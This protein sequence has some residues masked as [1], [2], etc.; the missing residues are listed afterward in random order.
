MKNRNETDALNELILVEEMKYAHNL[1]QLK[2]QFHIAYES[3]KPINL[4]KNAFHQI[5]ASPEIKN[6][7]VSNILGLATGFLS[8]RF[9][10]GSPHNPVKKVL[11]TLFQFAVGNMV[12]RHSDGIK[13]IGGNLLKHFLKK[14][15]V[16]N[17]FQIHD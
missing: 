3:V 7:L 5:T 4:I 9:L 6:D 8:K 15:L 16:L 1:T 13:S 14:R 12:S 2:E 11:G 10:I 17:K